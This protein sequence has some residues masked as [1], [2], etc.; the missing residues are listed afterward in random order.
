MNSPRVVDRVGVELRI[1]STVRRPPA[2]MLGTVT[3]VGRKQVDVVFRTD[4]VTFAVERSGFFRRTYRC[5]DLLLVDQ[6]SKTEAVSAAPKGAVDD[7]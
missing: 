1:G 3:H 2:D 5:P 6:P 7:H 4:P